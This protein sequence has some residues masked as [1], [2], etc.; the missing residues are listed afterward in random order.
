MRYSGLPLA[1]SSLRANN[2]PCQTPLC[3]KRRPP[4]PQQPIFSIFHRGG[5]HF[6]RRTTTNRDLTA[7]KRGNGT[8]RG[9]DTSATRRQLGPHAANPR[10][11]QIGNQ[12][13]AYSPRLV[14]NCGTRGQRRG[15][16]GL[17]NDADHPPTHQA[18]PVWRAT[19]ELRDERGLAVELGGGA[20]GRRGLDGM[21]T[22]MKSPTCV[23]GAGGSGGLG[24]ASRSTTPS[25]RLVCGDLAGGPPPTGTHTPATTTSTH[26]DTRPRPVSR[27]RPRRAQSTPLR[28]TAL[29]RSTPLNKAAPP[30]IRRSC[31][32]GPRPRRGQP[33]GGRRGRGRG[34]K[35]RSRHPR[36]GRSGSTAGLH[37]ARH[38]RRA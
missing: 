18:P 5:L 36:C 12:R 8:I 33:R 30:A 2:R 17:Q 21:C 13:R 7:S 15:L 23:E 32:R 28:T 1:T 25:R 10:A 3:P 27:P 22:A 16:A 37:R 38:T 34:S 35:T 4:R 14:P 19:R 6:E 9:P 24:R 26:N 29:R 20:R 31:P 11:G